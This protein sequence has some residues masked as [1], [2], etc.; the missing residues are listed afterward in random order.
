MTRVCLDVESLLEFGYPP[1]RKLES[2]LNSIFR[3]QHTESMCCN[4]Q[5]IIGYGCAF[6]L[7][8][9]KSHES[10]LLHF[11]TLHLPNTL[12]FNHMSNIKS[13]KWVSLLLDSTN[14]HMQNWSM[15]FDICP[16]CQCLLTNFHPWSHQILIMGNNLYILLKGELSTLAHWR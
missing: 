3:L 11:K 16:L 10:S 7:N 1:M 9:C 2:I 6:L 5:Q 12:W 8:F 4:Y 15:N 14:S 13:S